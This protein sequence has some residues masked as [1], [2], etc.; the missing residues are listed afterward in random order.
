MKTPLHLTTGGQ[1]TLGGYATTDNLVYVAGYPVAGVARS[2]LKSEGDS[3]QAC[4]QSQLNV[5]G[6]VNIRVSK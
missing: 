1:S 6:P 4:Y 5:A 2:S 3:S